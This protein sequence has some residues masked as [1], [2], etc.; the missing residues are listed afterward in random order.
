MRKT[1]VLALLLTVLPMTAQAQ[2]VRQ[3]FQDFGLIGVWARSCDQP[4]S[5]D[6]G[7]THAIYALAAGR[8]DG[9]MLTYDNGPNYAASVYTI[10]RAERSGRDHLTY[11]EERLQDK[12]R[13]TVTVHKNKDA[14]SLVSSVLA[15][16]TV[17]VR[18]GRRITNGEPSPPQVRCPK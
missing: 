5:A 13:V 1:P 17:L 6:N 11:L 10:L 18:D 12:K 3:V 14:I 4:A 9:V 8:G 7:N 15:D 2:S 16:G